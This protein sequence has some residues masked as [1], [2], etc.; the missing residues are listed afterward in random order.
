MHKL[1]ASDRSVLIKLATEL[2]KGSAERKAVLTGLAKQAALGDPYWLAAKFPGKDKNGKPFKKGEQVFYYPRTKTILTGEE[3]E[4]ASKD[5]NA[6]AFDEDFGY[7]GAAGGPSGT[8]KGWKELQNPRRWTWAT[9]A[10]GDLSFRV[11]EKEDPKI[12]KYYK[13]MVV[14]GDGTVLEALGQRLNPQDLFKRSQELYNA[15][16]SMMLDFTNQKE[17]WR[18]L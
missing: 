10:P 4:K 5:F 7:R 14:L 8:G 12:G 3:A 13:L 17:K 2:P 16:K 18:R 1:T 6:H 15:S 9:G 11:T